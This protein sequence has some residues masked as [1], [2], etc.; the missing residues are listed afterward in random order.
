MPRR[1]AVDKPL[2]LGSKGPVPN[3]IGHRFYDGYEGAR[4]YLEDCRADWFPLM[5][6]VLNAVNSA[7]ILATHA[8]FEAAIEQSIEIVFV[9]ALEGLPHVIIQ[10]SDVELSARLLEAATCM[11]LFPPRI[12]GCVP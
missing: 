10:W 4:R 11:C 5:E 7:S 1:A 9:T 2:V 8:G 3:E 12:W 6:K